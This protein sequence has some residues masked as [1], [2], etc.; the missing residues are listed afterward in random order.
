MQHGTGK[1]L[2]TCCKDCPHSAPAGMLQWQEL[3]AHA[4]A[5][6]RWRAAAA[7]AVLHAT[8]N[9]NIAM[10]VHDALLHMLLQ[11]CRPSS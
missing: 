4:H 11:V 7:H 8:T 10:P 3:D 2:S 1:Q 9:L 5:V 6:M